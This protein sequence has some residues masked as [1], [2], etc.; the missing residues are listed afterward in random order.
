MEKSATKQYAVNGDTFTLSYP[1]GRVW[2]NI[3]STDFWKY[4]WSCGYVLAQKL[5]TLD[6]RGKTFLE[7]GPGL[8]LCSIIAAFRGFTV[9]IVDSQQESLDY[10]THNTLA[11]GLPAPTCV[12][13]TWSEYKHTNAGKFDVIA[14]SDTFYST[15]IAQDAVDIFQNMSATDGVCYAVDQSVQPSLLKLLTT[16]GWEYTR[17]P[18]ESTFSLELDRG[19]DAPSNCLFTID[20]IRNPPATVKYDYRNTTPEVSPE[21]IITANGEEVLHVTDTAKGTI[22]LPEGGVVFA[23][24]K[25]KLANTRKLIIKEQGRPHQEMFAKTGQRVATTTRILKVGQS[26]GYRAEN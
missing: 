21:F 24:L 6:G 1:T 12:C 7:L 25:T 18:I 13:S 8:G 23:I 3:P 5:M 11:N 2:R 4:Q 17:E 20:P 10:V 9:T 22:Q 14:A 15:E 16:L 19:Y 26:I